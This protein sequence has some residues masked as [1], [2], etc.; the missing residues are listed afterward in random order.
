MNGLGN[1][2]GPSGEFVDP[3]ASLGIVCQPIY[4]RNVTSERDTMHGPESDH[5]RS[6]RRGHRPSFWARRLTDLYSVGASGV[7]RAGSWWQKRANRWND[8]GIAQRRGE[9]LPAPP[10]GRPIWIHAASVG[11]VRIGGYFAG[12]LRARGHTVIASAMTETGLRLCA[13]V[14]PQDTVCFRVPFDLPQAMEKV[15]SHFDPRAVVL[16]ETEWWPNFLTAAADHDVP[17]FVVN[18]R[19]SS[20]AFAR[21]RIGA[22]YW[23]SLL[24]CVRFFFMRAEDDA[25][26][27]LALGVEPWR[28]RAAGSLKL[29]PEVDRKM[30]SGTPVRATG[31][32]WIA[33][34]TR[35]GEEKIILSAFRQLR[36]EYAGLRLWLAPRHPER[37]DKVERQ[38]RRGGWEPS[39]WSRLRESASVSSDVLLIDQIGALA[40][41]YQHADVAFVGGSLRPFGGHNPLEAAAA[42]VPVVFGPFMEKQSEEAQLLL[43]MGMARRV[44][45]PS[46]LRS[47]IAT[48]LRNPPDAATRQTRSAELRD[49]LVGIREEI[50]DDLCAM[51]LSLESR[52]DGPQAAVPHAEP[53]KH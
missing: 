5:G 53:A 10:P 52:A 33:G 49:R 9:Q 21:Y 14:Y 24:R 12:A 18:G 22:A 2:E 37:F 30:P 35:P 34:C 51:L 31:P 42:G 41:L 47:A 32:V 25:H 20:G 17:V 50:A 16:V 45:D 27:V 46:L 1:C 44:D 29:P 40:G 19:V 23:R 15:F 11:E 39:R 4:I 43:E 48:I 13:D 38:I 6:N 26:R 28:V 8:E 7:A 3:E 36:R